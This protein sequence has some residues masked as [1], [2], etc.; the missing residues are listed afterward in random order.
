MRDC[1]SNML[2]RV[3]LELSRLYDIGIYIKVFFYLLKI[4]GGKNLYL[5]LVFFFKKRIGI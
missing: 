2:L 4:L 1:G 5:R 3:Y